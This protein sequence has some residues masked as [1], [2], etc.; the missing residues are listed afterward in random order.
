MSLMGVGAFCE[1]QFEIMGVEDA[2]LFKTCS[3]A[4]AKSDFFLHL[5]NSSSQAQFIVGLKSLS[6]DS[7]P[8]PSV[9]GTEGRCEEP[10]F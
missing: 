2:E 6:I 5:D 3:D 10:A 1:T 8:P 4:A 7:L 9:R